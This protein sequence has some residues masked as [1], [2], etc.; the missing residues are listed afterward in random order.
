MHKED[1]LTD[2]A[3]I[4][5]E[6][7]EMPE[8]AYH[9]AIYYLT[10]D[11]DGPSLTLEQQDHLPLK[12]AVIQRYTT[13]MIRD[14]THE[15]RSKSLYRGLERCICNWQRLK[16]FSTRENMDI[17]HVRQKTAQELVAFL[18]ME[19]SD[20]GKGKYESCVNCSRTD[21][22]EFIRDLGLNMNK[23]KGL[24]LKLCR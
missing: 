9:G 18:K 5:E 15:N 12:K 16:L 6:S 1:I 24:L 22:E 7:G 21:L 10:R 14:L 4:I 17:S 20:V 11:P 3:L 19:S 2:E 13:I 23:I 8:V